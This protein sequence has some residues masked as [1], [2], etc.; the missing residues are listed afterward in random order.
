MAARAR[1]LDACATGNGGNSSTSGWG[2]SNC[3]ICGTN[4]NAKWIFSSFGIAK[5]WM[6][7]EVK[8]SDIRLSDSLRYFQT[9]T[10]V[11]HAFQAVFELPHVQADCFGR[12]DAAGVPALTLLSQL[13]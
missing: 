4:L 1:H 12:T 3:G 2:T 7:V 10:K 6:L 9:A 5:P 13:L 11:K 8:T